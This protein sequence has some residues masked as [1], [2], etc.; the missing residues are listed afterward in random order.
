MFFGLLGDLF[1]GIDPPRKV[2]PQL[3]EYVGLACEAIGNHPD[4]VFRLKVVQLEELLEIRH[5]V[6]VMG[7]P[8]AGTINSLHTKFESSLFSVC[9]M[10]RKDPSMENI[11]GGKNFARR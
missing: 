9:V 6:F 4:S 11:G 3:E 2:N 7:P 5:C 1:P 8:G 10:S